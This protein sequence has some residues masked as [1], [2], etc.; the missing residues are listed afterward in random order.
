MNRETCTSLGI[1]KWEAKR[2]E[3]EVG[4]SKENEERIVLWL[5]PYEELGY[6]RLLENGIRIIGEQIETLGGISRKDRMERTGES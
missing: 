1:T 6:W 4:E 5:E 2:E 3:N